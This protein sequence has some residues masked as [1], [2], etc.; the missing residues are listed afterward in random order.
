MGIVIPPILSAIAHFHRK[1]QARRERAR[2]R[3]LINSLPGYVQKDIGWS[4]SCEEW[5][6]AR[7]QLSPRARKR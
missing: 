5:Q 3:R 1:I 7:W 4:G 6:P 2:T